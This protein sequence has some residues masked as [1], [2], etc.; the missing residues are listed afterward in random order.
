MFYDQDSR[1]AIIIRIVS[2]NDGIKD[3]RFRQTA[4]RPRARC[5][6]CCYLAMWAMRELCELINCD[7]VYTR[8]TAAY[9]VYSADYRLAPS[10][11]ETSLQSNAVFHWLGANLESALVYILYYRSVP[12][13]CLFGESSD[14]I[15]NPFSII[16]YWSPHKMKIKILRF[17]YRRVFVWAHSF[18]SFF[19]H[20][21][22]IFL[23]L[24]LL[25]SYAVHIL[26]VCLLRNVLTSTS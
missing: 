18:I 4:V 8:Y 1:N 2:P 13:L 22:M 17:I 19:R 12:W 23:L 7:T 14:L 11:W 6:G 21:I 26:A 10:Q 3:S 24:I 16:I 5:G 9:Q 20:D 15:K 25:S